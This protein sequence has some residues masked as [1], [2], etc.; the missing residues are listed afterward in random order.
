MPQLKDA[1][2]LRGCKLT[3]KKDDLIE[4]LSEHLEA[5]PNESDG[6]QA[7]LPPV[8]PTPV[9]ERSS[10]ENGENDNR[11]NAKDNGGITSVTVMPPAA[12]SAEEETS[13]AAAATAVVTTPGE[14]GPLF[15]KRPSTEPEPATTTT[16]TTA[17]NASAPAASAPAVTM[18]GDTAAKVVKPAG[19]TAMAP[20]KSAVRRQEEIAAAKKMIQAKMEASTSD[21]KEG[22][23][24][25]TLGT[26]GRAPLTSIVAKDNG[27]NASK[28]KESGTG[29]AM[30]AKA[31]L[32]CTP[33]AEA[34]AS[35]TK[36][37]IA[38]A[39]KL[40]VPTTTSSSNATSNAS[41]AAA[42]G[43]RWR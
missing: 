25:S 20:T 35:S 41:S 33:A 36:L 40:K 30:G 14:L 8:P 4:R 28:E 19:S 7:P 32:K 21:N 10:E 43:S 12:P 39:A 3:G 34:V 2:R 24:T 16:T 23:A 9:T 37:T 38:A 22:T 29:A 31:A 5:N 27:T 6:Y 18:A 15:K 17:V 11:E 42:A 1:L 26:T 13:T